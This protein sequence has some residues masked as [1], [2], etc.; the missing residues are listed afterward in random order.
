VTQQGKQCDISLLD[1][2]GK[3]FAQAPI[4]EDATKVVEPVTDSSR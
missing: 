2:S 1:D 3:L 4:R